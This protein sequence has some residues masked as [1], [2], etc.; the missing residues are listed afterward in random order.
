MKKT[1]LHLWLFAA[2]L[3]GLSLTV[4]SCKDDDDNDLSPEEQ[5][6]QAQEQAEKEMMAFNVLDYL[7]DMSNAPEDYLT[8]SY[9]PTIGVADGAD[10]STRIVN[11]NDM[12]T[13]AMRFADL[14]GASIDEN[15]QTYTWSNDELGTLTYTKT[16]DG[17]SWATVDVSI[18][19]IPHLQ[20][21]IY[22]SPEQA[23]NNGKFDGTAYYR[24]GDVVKKQNAD[25]EDEFWICVRPAFGPEGKEDSHWV[26]ISSLPKNN[27]WT[28]K[29]SN[30]ID[31]ALPTLLGDNHEHS[32]NFA[33]MLFAIFFPNEWENNVINT[34]GITM[35]HDFDKENIM[36]HRQYFW[37]RVQKAWTNPNALTNDSGNPSGISLLKTLFGTDGTAEYFKTMLKSAD[38]LNLLTNGYSWNTT[39]S[40]KPTLYRYRFTNGEGKESNMH[41]E[42]IKGGVFSNYHSVSAEVIK[43]K[44]TLNCIK[45]YTLENPGWFVPGFFGTNNKHYI[46]RHSTGA[47]LSSDG[48]EKP[49]E[50]LK[51]VSEVY[52]YNKYYGISDLNQDPEVL[53][54][55][56]YA[57]DK[58]QQDISDFSGDS[59]YKVGDVFK[60]QKGSTWFVVNEAGHIYDNSPYSELIS[61]EGIEIDGKGSATNIPTRDKADRGA[62][63]LWALYKTYV[64]DMS[65]NTFTEEIVN[66]RDAKIGIRNLF[67][68]LLATA[69]DEE[70]TVHVGA[71]AYRGSTAGEQPLVRFVMNNKDSNQPF[72][73]YLWDKYPKT[74]DKTT[75]F[76]KDF[77][78]QSILL[79]HVSSFDFV[80]MYAEDAYAHMRLYDIYGGSDERSPRLA[81]DASAKNVENYFYDYGE[82]ELKNYHLDMWNAP[83]LVFR[84]T[85][86][87]DRGVEK[88]AA[89]TV[90]GDELTLVKKAY[91]LNDHEVQS[92]KSLKYYQMHQ[93]LNQAQNSRYLNGQKQAY[94]KWNEVWK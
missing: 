56:Y 23:D 52:R 14:A 15:T 36:Y 4:T 27:V 68:P 50:P 84:M 3:C 91:D 24:F 31:Y 6:Q 12:A 58:E 42:P 77:S 79:Q 55:S 16:N 92:K 9:E 63:L 17:K 74:P 40:N 65:S 53:K 2:L 94:K 46:I 33:E 93:L 30:N 51:G 10:A 44:I 71:Y 87:Y 73:F 20:K 72:Q 25:G 29:G 22:R 69:S 59:Y 78:D 37:Q 64:E 32:Q 47:K 1:N 82:W 34:K 66:L 39:F 83:V 38:G 75:L 67:A 19:Q 76:V 70:P 61:F 89:K 7:A 18:K 88:H 41:K 8:G 48:K 49:K 28:Y 62:M 57:D 35:F 80:K 43:A 86:V 11:T 90:D 81:A 60:D 85:A 26:T 45:A 5:E 13:A 21:I 54:S